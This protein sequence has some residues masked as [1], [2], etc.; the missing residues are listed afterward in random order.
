LPNNGKL[1]AIFCIQG[2]KQVEQVE[3]MPARIKIASI[4]RKAILSGE[5]AAGEQLSL[6]DMAAKLGVSRTPVREAFQTLESEGLIELR[7]NKG[8]VV[9]PIDEALISDHYSIRILLEGEAVA[10][11]IRNNMDPYPLEALQN[12]I[13]SEHS[14]SLGNIYEDYNQA[15]HTRIWTASQSQKLYIFCETLW[16]G[17]SFSRALPDE[18]HRRQSIAEHG[19]ILLFV[20]NGQAEEGRKAMTRHIEKGMK[21][22]LN[23]LKMQ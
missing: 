19:E 23:A 8:A 13:M 12:S 22:M 15:F 20:K 5:F 10:R 6:T 1:Y 16:N 7:M 21:N 2:E 3:M 14:L 17:P 9:K 18:D 4:M 11:A